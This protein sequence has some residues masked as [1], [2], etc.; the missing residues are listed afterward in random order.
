MYLHFFP[1]L[2]SLR[3]KAE[4]KGAL[5]LSNSREIFSFR[6]QNWRA[7][8]SDPVDISHQQLSRWSR[9][10]TKR[11]HQTNQCG[12]ARC[13]Q[14]WPVLSWW[15]TPRSPVIQRVPGAAFLLLTL[16][17]FPPSVVPVGYGHEP[18]HCRTHWTCACRPECPYEHRNKICSFVKGVSTS[19]YGRT[20]GSAAHAFTHHFFLKLMLCPALLLE[21][22]S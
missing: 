3:S 11:W 20:G 19:A 6:G 5:V 18:T 4:K 8:A 7:W 2:N 15:E 12:D 22:P 17:T 21:K 16:E 10:R 9:R 13:Y 1:L 14:N